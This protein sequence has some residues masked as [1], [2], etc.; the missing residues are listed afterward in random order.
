MTEIKS[1]RAPRLFVSEIPPATEGWEF[2]AVMHV[3]DSDWHIYTRPAYS[4][5]TGVKVFS[6]SKVP[7]KA[8]YW[9][10]WNG[11]RVSNSKDT[12]IL[13]KNRPALLKALE[14]ELKNHGTGTP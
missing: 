9:L 7:N 11:A 2:L 6:L 10:A 5:W 1:K 3:L 8:A 12:I 4:S 14:S 13:E